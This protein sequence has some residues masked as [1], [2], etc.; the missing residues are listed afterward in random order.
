MRIVQHALFGALLGSALAVAATGAAWAQAG[1]PPPPPPPPPA[2]AVVPMTA[3]SK[4][5]PTRNAAV[6]ASENA[7]EPGNQR[8][9]ERVIPQISIP[10]KPRTGTA[11]AAASAP[12]GS[13]SGRVNEG[14][15]RCMALSGLAEKAACERGL[16]ASA[17]V[18]P[19]R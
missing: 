8:P 1:T 19:Q 7:K 10:F 4:Q 11:P 17:P 12:P 2:S 16:P 18:K 5:S 15:A 9:E 13:V 3:A 14:A 6:M